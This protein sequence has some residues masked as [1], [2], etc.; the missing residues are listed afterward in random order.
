MTEKPTGYI[1]TH[2]HYWDGAVLRY[3]W[4]ESVPVCVNPELPK[5]R[6]GDEQECLEEYSEDEPVLDECTGDV[7]PAGLVKKARIGTRRRR[8]RGCGTKDFAVKALLRS[9]NRSVAAW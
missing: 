4:L 2:V 3:P 8:T 5:S 1:D 6:A 7:L 9:V